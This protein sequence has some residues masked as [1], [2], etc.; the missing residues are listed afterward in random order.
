MNASLDLFGADQHP[1]RRH[2][3]IVLKSTYSKTI[4]YAT[5]H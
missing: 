4:R 2:P 1:E 5:E 3:P